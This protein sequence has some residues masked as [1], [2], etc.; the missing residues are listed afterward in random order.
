MLYFINL[1]DFKNFLKLSQEECFF[2]TVSK[3]P[4]FQKSF[5][6]RKSKCSI[7]GKEQHWTSK[8]LLIELRARLDLVKWNDNFFE[9]CHMLI[10][11]W[12][13]KTRY[14]TSK[15]IKKLSSTI[16]FMCLLD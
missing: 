14:D 15:D 6:Q 7:F 11:E 2:D 1:A 5:K 12:N 13:S 16:E 10:S 9:E 8:Q 4:I 3:W